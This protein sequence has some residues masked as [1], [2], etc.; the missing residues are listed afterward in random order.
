M[1]YRKVSSHLDFGIQCGK[2][3]KLNMIVLKAVNELY[4]Q[5]DS[6]KDRHLVFLKAMRTKLEQY[7]GPYYQFPIPLILNV[8]LT[9][10]DPLDSEQV[11]S[12]AAT[13]NRTFPR[14]QNLSDLQAN[15]YLKL[16]TEETLFDTECP[17]TI[18]MHLDTGTE[19]H[20][21]MIKRVFT[22]TTKR[23]PPKFLLEEFKQC[24]I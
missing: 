10:S 8:N 21:D 24:L 6:A 2:E 13:F 15:C 3:R 9:T 17:V 19:S 1:R 18:H 11:E 7:L 12:I 4:N 5:G 20:I 22:Q 23:K 16:C 14:F